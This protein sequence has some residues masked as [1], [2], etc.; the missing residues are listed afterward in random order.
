MSNITV[1]CLPFA[2]GSKYSLAFLKKVLPKNISCHFLEYRG[3]GTRAKEDFAENISEVVDDVFKSITPL[4]DK[5]YAIY[6]HSMGAKI[7]YLLT[8]RIREEGKKMP[9][10]LFV[11][12][13]DGPSV[14]A[15]KSPKHLLPKN[16]FVTAVKEL[17]GLPDEILGHEE[18]LEYFE[19]ILRADFKI[20]ESYQYEGTEPLKIPLTVMVGDKED[21]Q[22]E[23]I[24][25]WQ[26]ETL[27][28]IKLYRLPG[29]HFFIYDHEKQI[30]KIIEDALTK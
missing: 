4:L 10:H 11:S 25:Q 29:N 2:G 21:M 12:G 18:M 9:I 13:T 20:S 17:G 1:F 22:E 24:L 28:P 30:G 23:D 14:P 26:N 8:L 5:P 3:R 27:I 6:G 7:A 16:E 15:R 19:P